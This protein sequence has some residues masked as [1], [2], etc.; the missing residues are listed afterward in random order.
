VMSGQ[1]YS[2]RCEGYV[3]NSETEVPSA[4][5]ASESDDEKDI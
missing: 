1:V 4:M 2:I 3:N 5:F